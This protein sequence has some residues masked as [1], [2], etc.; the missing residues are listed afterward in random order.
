MPTSSATLSRH[1]SSA[2]KAAKSVTTGPQVTTVLKTGA[3]TIPRGLPDRPQQSPWPLW[4]AFRSPSCP[5]PSWPPPRNRGT[6]RPVLR[7]QGMLR[8][9]GCSSTLS[10]RRRFPEGDSRLPHSWS[11]AWHSPGAITHRRGWLGLCGPREGEVPGGPGWGRQATGFAR[12][13]GPQARQ[14]KVSCRAESAGRL[15]DRGL[16]AGPGAWG[17]DRG[18]LVTGDSQ[19]LCAGG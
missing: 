19:A 17:A 11:L 6:Q 7:G 18:G 2:G 1:P 13:K 10:R 3:A 9:P 4:P 8:A 5:A 12:G 16:R 14:A 15:G